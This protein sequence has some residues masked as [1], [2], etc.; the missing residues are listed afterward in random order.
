MVIS[1]Y[2]HKLQAIHGSCLVSGTMIQTTVPLT[3]LES[4]PI[5]EERED[6]LTLIIGK[7]ANMQ[8]ATGSQTVT[9]KMV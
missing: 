4:F 5:R 9:V 3:Q 6:A 1:N 7:L 8:A 2:A